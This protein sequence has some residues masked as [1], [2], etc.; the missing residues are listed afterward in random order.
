RE[1]G[2]APLALADFHA[3][4]PTRSALLMNFTNVVS[5]DHAEELARRV[6]QALERPAP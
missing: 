6:A 5:S 3:G 2:L 4:A 1:H